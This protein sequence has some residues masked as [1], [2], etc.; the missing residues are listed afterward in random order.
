MNVTLV[1]GYSVCTGLS[2]KRVRGLVGIIPV[3]CSGVRSSDLDTE[4][5]F[6]GWDQQPP[7]EAVADPKN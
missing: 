1:T 2:L 4:S 3:S 6:P 7:I 5:C